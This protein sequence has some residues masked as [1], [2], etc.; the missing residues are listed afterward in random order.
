MPCDSLI[1]LR[2]PDARVGFIGIPVFYGA[3]KDENGGWTVHVKLIYDGVLFDVHTRPDD[4]HLDEFI[5]KLKK[6]QVDWAPREEPA[7]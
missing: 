7:P 2:G 4:D 6:R 3:I 5:D 1:E